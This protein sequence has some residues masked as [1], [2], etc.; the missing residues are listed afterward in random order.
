[1][2]FALKPTTSLWRAHVQSLSEMVQPDGWCHRNQLVLSVRSR[3]DMDV[4]NNGN[5]PIQHDQHL[6]SLPIAACHR[7]LLTKYGFESRMHE[8]LK[9]WTKTSLG[10]WTVSQCPGLHILLQDHEAGD[11][12]CH[13]AWWQSCQDQ[14]KQW[15]TRIGFLL[16]LAS[17]VPFFLVCTKYIQILWHTMTQMMKNTTAPQSVAH[18]GTSPQS[19]K[20]QRRWSPQW[21][22]PWQLPHF[23]NEKAPQAPGACE[24][25]V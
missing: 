13:P 25:E 15:W 4:N 20:I 18:L 11:Q 10:P 8:S 3:D 12:S 16:F 17:G 5:I 21:Q 24:K 1:M 9:S 2:S 6:C 7:M 19:S 22:L 23:C 14:G